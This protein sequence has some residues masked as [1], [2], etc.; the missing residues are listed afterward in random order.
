MLTLAQMVRKF[1]PVMEE[2]SSSAPESRERV[3]P[4]C[5]ELNTRIEKAVGGNRK[6]SNILKIIL[7]L[8]LML[9]LCICNTKEP[10]I[11]SLNVC[12]GVRVVNALFVL[13]QWTWEYLFVLMRTLNL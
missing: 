12:I 1:W 6:S 9:L 2:W 4:F 8:T 13:L 10:S 3:D 7:V 5:L 11:Y